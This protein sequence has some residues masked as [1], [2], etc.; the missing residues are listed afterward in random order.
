MDSIPHR[1]TWKIKNDTVNKEWWCMSVIPA[2]GRLNWVDCKFKAN[3]DYKVRPHLN[4][5][6]QKND[7]AGIRM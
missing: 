4:K 7:I 1:K 2:V 3:L 6:K 5:T